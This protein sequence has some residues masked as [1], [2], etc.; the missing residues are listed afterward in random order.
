MDEHRPV[1]NSTTS[2]E[3]QL[4]KEPIIEEQLHALEKALLEYKR[5]DSLD[6][7]YTAVLQI[8]GI[9]VYGLSVDRSIDESADD[10]KRMT[11]D[12][13]N[14]SEQF[15]A[16]PLL[17]GSARWTD[18]ETVEF[19]GKHPAN[20]PQIE[21]PE[22]PEE[23]IKV[24]L[25][26]LNLLTHRIHR[27][28]EQ[29][30]ESP[31]STDL[32][33]LRRDLHNQ[34]SMMYLGLLVEFGGPFKRAAEDQLWLYDPRED[35][36]AGY[37][38]P[39]K[40]RLIGDVVES[41]ATEEGV[42]IAELK[43]KVLDATYD[44]DLSLINTFLFGKQ[45]DHATRRAL[46][47]I[48]DRRV[49]DRQWQASVLRSAYVLELFR[50]RSG[51]T[52]DD[53]MMYNGLPSLDV[54]LQGLRDF[55][56]STQL[57]NDLSAHIAVEAKPEQ[58]AAGEQHRPMQMY[59]LIEERAIRRGF[60][61]RLPNRE[62]A[63]EY[64]RSLEVLWNKLFPLNTRL[65]GDY[66]CHLL[67]RRGANQRAGA[68][69]YY[70][71]DMEHPGT[72]HVLHI[73][74][75]DTVQLPAYLPH[76]KGHEKHAQVVALA[77]EKGLAEPRAY[78]SIPGGVSEAIAMLL[79]TSFPP[80]A[81]EEGIRYVG[82]PSET[83]KDVPPVEKPDG[84]TTKDLYQ[85]VVMRAFQA[86]KGFAGG[87]ARRQLQDFVSRGTQFKQSE[88]DDLVPQ[89]DAEVLKLANS[90]GVDFGA[91]GSSL[92]YLLLELWNPGDGSIYIAS[93]LPQV[94]YGLEEESGSDEEGAE[95]TDIDLAYEFTSRYGEK[96]LD[97]TEARQH[98]I[99][100]MYRTDSE[101]NL[102]K[103]AEFIRTAKPEEVE[104]T[105]EELGLSD[106]I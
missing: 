29:L 99:A 104:Q 15:A 30:H 65:A 10:L 44:G 8:P 23:R 28:E 67:T 40:S 88:A 97:R 31:D 51:L 45:G 59:R 37:M 1:V 78:E 71:G 4:F 82:D 74:T 25:P 48:L 75:M 77:G 93:K 69:T 96:W 101:R 58:D 22:K 46:E 17:A 76:E 11:D 21:L 105:L 79:E 66:S 43:Q 16:P 3:L 41:I 72:V 35:E 102:A 20:R 36:E 19:M 73:P 95:E 62:R 63:T 53:M 26:V 38:N 33:K 49:S 42:D 32:Q 50:Q 100:L 14:G 60:A 103:L 91:R 12:I 84:V 56:A 52:L 86:I 80:I 55:A 70:T 54:T 7:A 94:D 61:D 68:N 90:T 106:Y 9:E 34:R 24:Y 47:E 5:P 64:A 81:D 39:Q 2:P 6:S 89:I 85:T 13:M 87:E 18:S 98:L 92:G 57:H 27:V 83:N